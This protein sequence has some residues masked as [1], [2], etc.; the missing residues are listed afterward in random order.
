MLKNKNFATRADAEIVAIALSDFLR[1]KKFADFRKDFEAYSANI[2][3]HTQ[4]SILSI[5]VRTYIIHVTV[6]IMN[7]AVAKHANQPD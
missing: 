6:E 4:I 2:S 3:L 7:L 1:E 5:L